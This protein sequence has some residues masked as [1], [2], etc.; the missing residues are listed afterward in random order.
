MPKNF[1]IVSAIKF[2][3]LFLCQKKIKQML[4]EDLFIINVRDDEE[5]ENFA[6]FIFINLNDNCLQSE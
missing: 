3:A 1:I 4:G 5:E 2:L 6:L